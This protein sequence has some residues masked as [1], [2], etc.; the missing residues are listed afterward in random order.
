M[1]DRVLLLA[2]VPESNEKLKLM[3]LQQKALKIT[4]E[5]STME[6]EPLIPLLHINGE[7]KNSKTGEKIKRILREEK[8]THT[9]EQIKPERLLK[10]GK[11]LFVTL[12]T[13]NYLKNLRETLL[14]MEPQLFYTKTRIGEISIF[15]GILLARKIESDLSRVKKV[16][17]LKPEIEE[18]KKFKLGILEIEYVSNEI[19]WSFTEILRIHTG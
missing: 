9:S 4:G 14:N 5:P 17:Q 7:V 15:D 18:I 19:L 16:I 1:Q 2:L 13:G 3:A 11:S 10:V 6:L 12:E 8:L